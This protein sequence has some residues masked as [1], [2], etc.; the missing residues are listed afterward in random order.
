MRTLVA[1]VVVVLMAGLAACATPIVRE[2]V[3][4]NLANDAQIAGMS[5]IRG[6]GDGGER[7]AQ[8]FI[9]AEQATLRR[10][11]AN[12][13]SAGGDAVAHMLAISGGADDGAFGAGL[14]VGWTERGT[15]PNFD[16][17]TGISAGALISPFA[18]LGRDYDRQ[19]AEIF[20]LHGEEEIFK[21]NILAGVLGG[22]AVADNAPL[23]RL[24]ARYIDQKLL[25]RVAAERRKGRLLLVGTTNLDAQ[26]PVFW[27]MGRI[28]MQGGAKSVNLFRQVLLASAALPGIFPPV[29]IEVTAG[30]QKYRELHVD[31]GPTRQVFL[32]PAEFRFDDLDRALGTRIQRHIWVIRNGKIQP[33]YAIV[34]PTAL[35]IG[36]RSLDTLTKNQ[37][38]GDLRRI[39]EKALAE[40]MTFNLASIPAD[41]DAPRP[42]PFDR[43]YMRALFA[44]GL[45]LGRGGYKWLTVLPETPAGLLR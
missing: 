38:L 16:L 43:G 39:Q 21:A 9:K 27:D 6:W 29:Q 4:A 26:R 2:A 3:P 34:E 37:S 19:L 41:F 5:G 23:E 7:A 18:F 20:T 10:K 14:L 31:G 36:E 42:V 15:R 44:R 40:N 1:L 32:T 12:R 24:I 25:D 28:A 45:A 30:G 35:K 33:E 22:P 17:V 11:Y 8:A 13:T